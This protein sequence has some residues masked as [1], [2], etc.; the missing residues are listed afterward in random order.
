MF[1]GSNLVLCVQLFC[2]VVQEVVHMAYLRNRMR[3]HL[4]TVRVQVLDLTVVGPL[5]RDVE[6]GG[7]WATVRV[8]AVAFEQILVQL[9]V[10]IVY[11]VVEG[12]QHDLRYLLDRHVA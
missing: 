4:V 6:G 3:S 10:Q 7:D 8:D 9:L 12:Q 5:V 1:N 11:R 2:S